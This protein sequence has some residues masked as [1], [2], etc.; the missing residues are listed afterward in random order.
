MDF[1][2]PLLSLIGR[3]VGIGIF[4]LVFFLQLRANNVP[5]D[6]YTNTRILLTVLLSGIIIF[7]SPSIAYLIMRSFGGESDFLRALS[8]M[9]GALSF[10]FTAVLFLILYLQNNKKDR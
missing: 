4:V 2:S 1:N 10:I 8:S 6:R 3:I 9:A 7:T 5:Q